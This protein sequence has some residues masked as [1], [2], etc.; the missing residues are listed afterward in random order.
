MKA[1][2]T[3]TGSRLHHR[4]A[5]KWKWFGYNVVLADGATVQMP[6]TSENQAAFPQPSHQKPGLG[7][8][9]VRLVALTS[10]AAGSIINYK[11]A[12]SGQANRRIIVLLHNL[13]HKTSHT[14]F[15]QPTLAVPWQV[16]GF[17]SVNVDLC[18]LM[19]FLPFR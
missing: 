18:L 11:L 1:A 17:V 9:M 16:N 3:N 5:E 2:A 14:V 12:L 7:F 15:T 19:G 6:D 8:P 10:L 13:Y 4:S